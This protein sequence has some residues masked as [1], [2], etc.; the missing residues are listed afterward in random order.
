MIALLL[1][2]IQDSPLSLPAGNGEP[3]EL[4]IQKRV[5]AL[6]EHG[7][8]RQDEQADHYNYLS[9]TNSLS[10]LPALFAKPYRDRARR[11][12]HQMIPGIDH[13]PKQ[14]GSGRWSHKSKHRAQV[15][16]G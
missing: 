11:E 2:R 8:Q 9:G 4:E 7:R 14:R 13:C 12:H 3:L 5:K 1:G 10:Y 16:Y 15:M 6:R